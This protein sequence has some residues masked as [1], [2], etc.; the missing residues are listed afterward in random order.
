MLKKR[1]IITVFR[2]PDFDVRI[3]KLTPH[4]LQYLYESRKPMNQG[5]MIH[6]NSLIATILKK[7]SHNKVY[8]NVCAFGEEVV[9]LAHA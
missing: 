2:F 5:I 6:M 1:E 3:L 9:T 4:F 8:S 7:Y